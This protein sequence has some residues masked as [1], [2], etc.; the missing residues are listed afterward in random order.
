MT[1]GFWSRAI[2]SA[3]EVCHASIFWKGMIRDFCK[4]R[5]RKLKEEIDHPKELA[6]GGN[7]R[8]VSDDATGA[9]DQVREMGNIGTPIA[10]DINLMIDVDPGE[11]QTFIEPI[12]ILLEEW[13]V[14]RHGRERKSKKP[15][16]MVKT[17]KATT[18]TYELPSPNDQHAAES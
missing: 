4:I 18:E 10:K 9:I 15:E 13:Y 6:D 7:T 8:G 2:L 3:S 17:S 16:I 1:Q 14:A 12:G 11:S 5:K